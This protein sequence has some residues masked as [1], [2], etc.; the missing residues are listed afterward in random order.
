VIA[1]GEGAGLKR[2]G[3]GSHELAILHLSYIRLA[4]GRAAGRQGLR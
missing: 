1:R 4:N 3:D 2:R